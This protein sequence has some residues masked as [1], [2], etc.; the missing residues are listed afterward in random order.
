MKSNKL[1]TRTPAS[2]MLST[3]SNNKTTKQGTLSYMSGQLSAEIYSSFYSYCYTLS[4]WHVATH[5][6]HTFSIEKTISNKKF[7][8]FFYET[9]PQLKLTWQ[10]YSGD[11]LICLIPIKAP[12][13]HGANS[14]M[15]YCRQ[16]VYC[17]QVAHSMSQHANNV[18]KNS[19]YLTIFAIG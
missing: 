1:F 6:F 4:N 5:T 11:D 12:H 16:R 2:L 10:A 18:E 15:Q 19:Y 3:I 13:I 7:Y 14:V 17:C 8:T 9:W